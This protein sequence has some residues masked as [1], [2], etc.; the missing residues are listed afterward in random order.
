[1]GGGCSDFDEDDSIRMLVTMKMIMML[2]HDETNPFGADEDDDD[3][4]K[5]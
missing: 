1:M 3:A 2:F 5:E 4:C